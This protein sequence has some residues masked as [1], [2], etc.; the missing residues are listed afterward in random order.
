MLHVPR[1]YI[2]IWKKIEWE[3]RW[4]RA[5]CWSWVLK[6]KL[7]KRR[8]SK[9]L[10]GR[11]L[12]ALT[13][14]SLLKILQV[15]KKSASEQFSEFIFWIWMLNRWWCWMDLGESSTIVLFVVS[16]SACLCLYDEA[17][18]LRLYYPYMWCRVKSIVWT[19][20]VIGIYSEFSSIQKCA[21]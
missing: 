20:T 19:F 7:Q 3:L 14:V 10:L 12:D 2:K 6:T 5:N 13:Q 4:C 16:W 1:Y 21:C 11:Q 17:K 15:K 8:A 18:R 9:S